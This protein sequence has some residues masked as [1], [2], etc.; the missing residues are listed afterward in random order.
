MPHG[1][2][3]IHGVHRLNLLQ[4]RAIVTAGGRTVPGNDDLPAVRTTVAAAAAPHVVSVDSNP[5][6][7]RADA[8]GIH[9]RVPELQ[10]RHQARSRSRV[11]AVKAPAVSALPQAIF[12]STGI[13]ADATAV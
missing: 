5:A 10:D 7:W 12:S 3:A 4:R 6:V 2:V 9:A 8:H 11:Q 13:L 1:T